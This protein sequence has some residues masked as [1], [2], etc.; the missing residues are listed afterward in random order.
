MKVAKIRGGKNMKNKKKVIIIVAVLVVVLAAVGV[1][2]YDLYQKGVLVQETEKLSQIDIT[3]EQIDMTIYSAGR[4]GKIE[5][6][7]KEYLNEF[8]KLIKELVTM[9]SNEDLTNI[10]SIQNYKEDGPDFVKT[11][12]FVTDYKQKSEEIIN[13]ISSM[14]EEDAMM[15][16]IEEVEGLSKKDHE[17]YRSLMLNDE[18]RE[19]L[20]KSK[21]QIEQAKDLFNKTLEGSL[22][23]LNFL[24]ENKD[25]WSLSDTNILFSSVSDLQRYNELVNALK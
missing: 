6:A 11:K 16:K 12:A 21:E 22:N 24:S 7:E 9:Y 3:S 15:K 17:L 2:G 5:K 8:S 10:L 4:Y 25:S 20:K 18:T 14:I 23:I 13:Q 1:V 19:D